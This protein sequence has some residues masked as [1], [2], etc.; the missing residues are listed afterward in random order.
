MEEGKKVTDALADALKKLANTLL[1]SGLDQLFGVSGQNNWFSGLFSSVFGGG[2]GG[3]YGTYD[4]GVTG[5]PWAGLRFAKGTNSAPGGVA[6]VGEEGPELVN[7]PKG[8]QVTPADMTR[9]IIGGA[10]GAAVTY[11][12]V[13]NFQGTSQEL[14]DFRRQADRDRADFSS[15]VIQTIRKANKSHMKLAL[16]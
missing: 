3:S 2:G 4:A 12:P 16:S 7:L 1:Q 6:L 14:A 13:Y 8:S 5:D 10:G 15:R 11:A 9:K